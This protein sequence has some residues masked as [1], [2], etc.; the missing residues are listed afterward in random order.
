MRPGSRPNDH[1]SPCPCDLP[2]TLAPNNCGSP[3]TFVTASMGPL[4]TPWNSVSPDH[5]QASSLMCTSLAQSL[6][7]ITDQKSLISLN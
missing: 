3:M 1:S 4:Q 7:Q 5:M 2:V 6:K